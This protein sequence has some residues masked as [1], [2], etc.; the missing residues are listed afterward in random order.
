MGHCLVAKVPPFP[1]HSETGFHILGYDRKCRRRFKTG[2]L[3]EQRSVMLRYPQGVVRT[4]HH[5]M[6]H[7][8]A[9]SKAPTAP[10]RGVV[11]RLLDFQSF[12]KCHVYANVHN[13]ISLRRTAP[14]LVAMG[15][16]TVCG[17]VLIVGVF[18]ADI[19]GPLSQR[20][21]TARQDQSGVLWRN[22][23]RSRIRHRGQR[24]VLA[25][26]V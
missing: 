4:G 25:R 23:H 14:V 21:R 1:L 2:F 3:G 24:G 17:Y 12:V 5:L 8:R 22:S 13:W 19:P 16:V 20:R 18:Q 9:S 11:F 26:Q 6:L 10:G 7:G 15:G